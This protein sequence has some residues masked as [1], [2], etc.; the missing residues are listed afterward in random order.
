[1]NARETILSNLRK[2]ERAV[3]H[4]P[5]WRS[6]RSIDDLAAHFTTALTKA[7]GEVIRATNLV[8]ATDRLNEVLEELNAQ[9]VVANNEAPLN[10]LNLPE[11]WPNIAWHLVDQS[12]GDLR[13][14]CTTADVGLSSA[15]AA[16]A[17]TGSIIIT[18][19]LGRSRL[20]TLLPS[21]HL[22]LVPTSRLTGDLFTWTAARSGSAVIEVG[23][24]GGMPAS[25]VLVSG[26]SKTADIEQTMA[27]GVH[28]PKRFIVIL[29]DDEG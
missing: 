16:L 2:K 24:E 25:I 15:E 14:F 1:M 21:V 28:G 6:R 22:A 20:A 13:S 3:T 8:E 11:R 7:K 26:P 27:V 19:G 23:K 5:A 4:P 12:E 17:E 18:S 29:Y 10:Q 9:C